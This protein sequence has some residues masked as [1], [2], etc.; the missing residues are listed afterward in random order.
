[1]C[2][3]TVCFSNLIKWQKSYLLFHLCELDLPKI[4]VG[5][6]EIFAHLAEL[7]PVSTRARRTREQRHSDHALELLPQ[8][9]EPLDSIRTRGRQQFTDLKKNS[10][11]TAPRLFCGA[12]FPPSSD[13]GT[14]CGGIFVDR[15]NWMQSKIA[16]LLSVQWNLR[17][18]PPCLQ[19]SNGT[20]Y[21][22][23]SRWEKWLQQSVPCSLGSIF[24]QSSGA[25][26]R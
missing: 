3:I 8:R 15:Q 17:A 18:K 19:V 13:L 4:R 10:H 5:H 24:Q 26:G 21:P 2:L 9:A 7:L 22:R 16:A 23:E 6:L 20:Y 25:I 11:R 12:F 14:G 1:M